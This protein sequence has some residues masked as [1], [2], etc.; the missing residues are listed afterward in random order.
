MKPEELMIALLRGDYIMTVSWQS[1]AKDCK[2][3][4]V[5]PRGELWEFYLPAGVLHHSIEVGGPRVY[6]NRTWAHWVPETPS[7]DCVDDGSGLIVRTAPKSKH[8][9]FRRTK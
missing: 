7:G 5:I 4:V 8:S 3:A 6:R 1:N 2:R 9:I